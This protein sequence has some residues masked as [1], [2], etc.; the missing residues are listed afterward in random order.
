MVGHTVNQRGCRGGPMSLGLRSRAASPGRG[1]LLS[2]HNE[3]LTKLRN[4]LRACVA[5]ASAGRLERDRW[6]QSVCGSVCE[7]ARAR[8]R[9]RLLV[10]VV[11]AV[12]LEKQAKGENA[13]F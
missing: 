8:R 13:S 2:R 1:A 6:R 5:A 7:G 10:V 11:V 9:S 12:G 4:G 3:A